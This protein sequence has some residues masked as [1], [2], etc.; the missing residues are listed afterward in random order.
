V[1]REHSERSD[2]HLD[3]CLAQVLS[4]PA[5]LPQYDDRAEARAV[6]TRDERL[7]LAVG[8]VPARRRVEEQNRADQAR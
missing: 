2:V 6:E 1:P 5:F 3:P 4:Q 8:A 7:E